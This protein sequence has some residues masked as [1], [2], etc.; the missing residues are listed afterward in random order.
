FT[1]IDTPGHI[2]F[3][4]EVERSL[5]VLDGA[6]TVLSGVAGIQP[7]TETVWR[8]AEKHAVPMIIFVNKMDQLGADFNRVMEQVRTRLHARPIALMIPVGT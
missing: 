7:Q 8:Q 4:I 6:I 1:L 3:A 2:D 5:R